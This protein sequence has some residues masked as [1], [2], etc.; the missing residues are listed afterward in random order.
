MAR[1]PSSLAEGID[2][3]VAGALCERRS[4]AQQESDDRAESHGPTLG[5]GWRLPRGREAGERGSG[6]ND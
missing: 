6:S 5:A 4:G 2:V 1:V 3:L